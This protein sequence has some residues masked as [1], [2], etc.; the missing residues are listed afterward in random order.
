MVRAVGVDARFDDD[1]R[2]DAP[3]ELC[4]VPNPAC[5]AARRAA[6]CCPDSAGDAALA[7][8]GVVLSAVLE[9]TRSHL[10]Q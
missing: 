6:F 8:A 10:L 5:T 1:E 4:V 7:F 2:T 3:D 9:R